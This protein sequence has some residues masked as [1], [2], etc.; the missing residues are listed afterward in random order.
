MFVCPAERRDEYDSIAVAPLGLGK[1][2]LFAASGPTRQASVASGME[3][4][5]ADIEVVAVH[6]GARPLVS[7]GVVD[8]AIALLRSSGADGVVIGHPAYDTLK[9]VEGATSS[10]RRTAR[11]TGSPRRR[12]CSA[13]RCID[14]ALAAAA[15]DGFVATDDSGLVEHYGGRVLV[16]EGP[17]DN[18]KV[19]VA[20]DLDYVG[21]LLA[22]R[23]EG[24]R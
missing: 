3:R 20:D 21:S 1:P 6:D 14:D 13:V 19:T 16:M 23:K 10:R 15:L 12:R 9:I 18:V 2:V 22:A 11:C 7:P 4:L 17:R 24:A 8:E 5:T